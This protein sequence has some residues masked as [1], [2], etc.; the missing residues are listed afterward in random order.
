VT[1]KPVGNIDR[2]LL[3]NLKRRLQKSGNIAEPGPIASQYRHTGQIVRARPKQ[4]GTIFLSGKAAE[5]IEEIS[6]AKL[7]R[8]GLFKGFLNLL[9]NFRFRNPDL[10]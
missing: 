9:S 6:M 5:I 10:P 4:K 7:S 1:L 2:E 8:P 3:P